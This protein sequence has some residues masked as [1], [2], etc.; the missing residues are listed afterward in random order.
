MNLLLVNTF[1]LLLL[2]MFARRVQECLDFFPLVVRSLILDLHPENGTKEGLLQLY[3]FQE[4]VGMAT[5]FGLIAKD[6]G[7]SFSLS[8][9]FLEAA[10]FSVATPT[11]PPHAP[12]VADFET[13][14]RTKIR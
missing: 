14:S 8:K 12:S 2:N 3:Q 6:S 4:A 5:F 1:L 7:F 13:F 9:D 10:A 11:T